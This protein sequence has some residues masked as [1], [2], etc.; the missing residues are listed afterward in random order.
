MKL[1]QP[2]TLRVGCNEELVEISPNARGRVKVRTSSIDEEDH[3]DEVWCLGLEH[4]KHTTLD[5]M[6]H[7]KEICM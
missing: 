2:R 7:V 6:I 3:R 5:R 4:P 1:W